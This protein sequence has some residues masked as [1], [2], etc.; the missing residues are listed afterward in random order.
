VNLLMYLLLPAAIGPELHSSS[1]RN[2]H[3]KQK[4]MFMWSKEVRRVGN[5]TAIDCLEN[6]GSSTSCN[7]SGFNDFYGDS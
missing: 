7:P 6:V 2:E 5:L 4:I 1:N 3:Q